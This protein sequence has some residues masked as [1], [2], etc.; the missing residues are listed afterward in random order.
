M[1]LPVKIVSAA[2]PVVVQSD[3][4][5]KI[6]T[7]V[8]VISSA[9]VVSPFSAFMVQC[10]VQY[11]IQPPEHINGKSLSLQFAFIT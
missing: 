8:R 5:V 11:L 6:V 3:L 10:L 7:K 9:R 2:I 1:E 4:K